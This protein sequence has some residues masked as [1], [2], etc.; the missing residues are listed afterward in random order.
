[1]YNENVQR[2]GTVFIYICN[3][4]DAEYETDIKY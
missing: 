1:M 2:Y 4:A 3:K